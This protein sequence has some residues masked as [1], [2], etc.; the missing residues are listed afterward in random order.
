MN[1]MKHR[2]AF[3]V[4][5][6][7]TVALSASFLFFNPGNHW[8]GKPGLALNLG[9]DFTGG[10]KIYFP[11]SRLVS[12]KEVAAVLKTIKLPDF[13]Y[14]PPQPN[15]FTDSTGVIRHQ[16]L[17][18]TRFLNDAEQEIV[19]KAL[20]AKFGKVEQNQGLDITRVDPLIGNEMV[21][22]ALLAVAIASVLMLAYIWFRFELISGVAAVLALIHDSLL[23]LGLFALFQKE[24]SAT[25]IAAILTVVGYSINDTIVVFD[26]IRENL[27]Y[28]RKDLSFVEVVNDS[29]LQTFRRSLNTSL[30]TLLAILVFYIA[31]P[32]IRE[33]CFAVIIGIT[34]GTYSSIFVASPIWAVFKERQE[35]R[36]LANKAARAAR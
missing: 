5:F 25:M 30:T 17:V 9:V 14:N 10:T 16:V 29:I 20:E 31:V 13:K 22:K 12:S 28:R 18:Y 3:V 33:F 26:R 21:R 6:V 1:L 32:N 27:K 36:Q 24:I 11:V 15:F 7:V 2:R 35:K 8:G 23:V 34:A 4:I 19:V